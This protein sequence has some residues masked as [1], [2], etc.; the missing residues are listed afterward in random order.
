LEAAALILPGAL[1]VLCV[2]HD[3][4][5]E[6]L[7]AGI[8]H[9]GDQAVLFPTDVEHNTVTDDAGG[10]VIRSYVGPGFPGNRFAVDVGLPCPKRPLGVIVSQLLPELRE[11]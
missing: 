9:A 1:V 7:L 6:D 3:L 2:S 8:Q 10:G 4:E 11:P 5:D